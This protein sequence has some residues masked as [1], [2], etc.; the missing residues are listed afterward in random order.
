M[1]ADAPI[2]AY[3][4]HPWIEAILKHHPKLDWVAYWPRTL[5]WWTGETGFV[6]QTR[7]GMEHNYGVRDGAYR[8]L[9]T[10]DPRKL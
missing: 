1:K 3:T 6:V 2:P 8:K 5:N 4:K 7:D 10:Y 9:A